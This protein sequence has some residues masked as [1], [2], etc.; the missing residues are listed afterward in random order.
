[1]PNIDIPTEC[2]DK[3]SQAQH[4][5][6]RSKSTEMN[7]NAAEMWMQPQHHT[8]RYGKIHSVAMVMSSTF[9]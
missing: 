5:F 7:F 3:T 6:G 2:S 9:E 8:H 4:I 1:M